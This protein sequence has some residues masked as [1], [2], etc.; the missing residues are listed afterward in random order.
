MPK[1]VDR[2]QRPSPKRPG[3]GLTG[4]PTGLRWWELQAKTTVT[5]TVRTSYS[6]VQMRPDHPHLENQALSPLPPLARPRVPTILDPMV[7][8]S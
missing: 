7:S 8:S 1:R 5:S 3:L 2:N 6:G 4:G